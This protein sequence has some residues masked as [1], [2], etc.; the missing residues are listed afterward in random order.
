MLETLLTPDAVDE[1]CGFVLKDGTAV[2]VAN[3]HANPSVGYEMDP[4]AALKVMETGDVVATWHT[5]PDSDPNLSGEDY[6]GFL[7]W[8]DLEHA[9]I[10][11]R[12]GKVV[13][14]RFKVEDGLV[15]QC[16]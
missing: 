10:G 12:D 16:D 13:V 15:M 7:S 14:A 6:S 1:R 8:P 9:I 2:E 3:I 4:V 5:H 11:W